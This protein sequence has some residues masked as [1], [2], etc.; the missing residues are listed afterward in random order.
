[1]MK[2]V[3]NLFLICSCGMMHAQITFTPGYFVDE[4][5]TTTQ[6]LIKNVGWQNN[7][8]SFDYKINENDQPKNAS[9][10][11]IKEFGVESKIYR[12][13]TVQIDRSSEL[14]NKI[15]ENP[16][17]VFSTETLFLEPLVQGNATLY[18]YVGTN[19]KRFF[20]TK[21]D[22]EIR[23]LIYKKFLGPDNTVGT[24]NA[25]RNQL[26][27]DISCGSMANLDVK[28]IDYNK[29]ELVK[30]FVKYNRCQNPNFQHSKN[31]ETSSFNLYLKPGVNFPSF[32]LV[33][34]TS[35]SNNL[36]FSG[37][38]GFRAG[39]EFEVILPFNKNKWALFV[40]PTYQTFNTDIETTSFNMGSLD[41]SSIEIPIGVRH[42]FFISQ[43]SQ[44][45]INAAFIL[46]VPVEG[47]LDMER[48]VDAEVSGSDGLVCGAGFHYKGRYRLE[49]RYGFDRNLFR[50][51]NFWS[52]D[53]STIGVFLGYNILG[54]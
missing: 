21:S 34:V 4:N 50:E 22:G 47:T 14:I 23:S 36:E 9:V 10:N 52:S 20:Y 29:R 7:P 40:E 16:S 2:F 54:K 43:E 19:L 18:M 53:Y 12:R 44:I 46:D 5:G 24:N 27:T 49:A 13:F 39:V 42:Y 45:F 28:T 3:L 6:C 32:T 35:S 8:N 33:S 15:D 48:F 41:Y 25:F 38:M 17:P 51:E 30:H 26:K 31:G 1:M 11:S 37:L